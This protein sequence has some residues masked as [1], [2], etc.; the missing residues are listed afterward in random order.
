MSIRGQAKTV[1]YSSNK[2]N[3]LKKKIKTNLYVLHMYTYINVYCTLC[4]LHLSTWR[5]KL[6][7]VILP[8]PEIQ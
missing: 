5:I 4:I 2:L 8:N 6:L 3:I 1:L 7:H